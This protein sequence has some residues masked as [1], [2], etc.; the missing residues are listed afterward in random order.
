MRKNTEED[1]WKKVDKD[2]DGCW[3]WRGYVTKSGYG[4]FKI[5]NAIYWTHRLSF[6]Y[7]HGRWPEEVLDHLCETKHCVNPAHLEEVSHR[8][9]IRRGNNTKLTEANV[10]DI[11][12]YLSTG[13]KQKDIARMFGLSQQHIS[14]IST[15]K[16]WKDI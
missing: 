2:P 13:L 7:T 5:N 8:V 1:F 14:E 3:Y 15:G 9:N 11:K 6:F 16:N 10:V 12:L 4:S